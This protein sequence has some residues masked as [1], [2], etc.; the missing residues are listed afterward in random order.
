MEVAAQKALEDLRASRLAL[1]TRESLVQTAK[2]ALE[3]EKAA[4]ETETATLT[5]GAEDKTK[6]EDSD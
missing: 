6:S 1:A 4:L 2:A 5:T 3:T